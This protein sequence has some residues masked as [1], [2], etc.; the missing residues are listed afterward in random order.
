MVRACGGRRPASPASRF[1]TA[2]RAGNL[3]LTSG[4][5]PSV[6]DLQIRGKVGRDIDLRTA[7]KAAELCAVNCLRAV[8]AVADLESI[9]RVVKVFG[10]VNVAPDFNDTASVINGCSDF[11][12]AVLGDR[13]GHHA[14]SAVGM[15]LPG[16]WVVEI[17]MIVA[18]G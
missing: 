12:Q 5:V 13:G 17:E 4:Q 11:L 15:T 8:S 6:G 3:V 18:V 10:M 16:D 7:Q 14:R 1:H 9:E 2:V